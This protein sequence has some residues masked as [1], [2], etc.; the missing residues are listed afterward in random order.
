MKTPIAQ[1]VLAALMLA[2][3]AA[4]AQS[5]M[6][7]ADRLNHLALLPGPRLLSPARGSG[8]SVSQQ[9]WSIRRDSIR[10][11]TIGESGTLTL[12]GRSTPLSS[13]LSLFADAAP[14][15]ENFVRRA[16]PAAIQADPALFRFDARL[17]QTIIAPLQQKPADTASGLK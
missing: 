4:N 6:H 2:P 7:A 1:F 5:R 15:D 14:A 11:F 10:L 3:F 9:S 17:P 13:A 12:G 8:D 16:A